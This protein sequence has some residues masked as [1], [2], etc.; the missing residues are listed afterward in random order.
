[1]LLYFTL[2]RAI[3]R[4]LLLS[5]SPQGWL[6]LDL[7]FWGPDE[8]GA[9]LSKEAVPDDRVIVLDLAAEHYQTGTKQKKIWPKLIS[10][11][12]PVNKSI[13]WC[14][15]HNYGGR[16]DIYGNLSDIVIT[17]VNDFESLQDASASNNFQSLM[18]GR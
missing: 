1:M 6:F 16:R 18:I 3:L 13:I 8:I 7:D 2:F 4:H 5:C 15:L 17:P 10:A 14:A 11:N 9:Y 12:P